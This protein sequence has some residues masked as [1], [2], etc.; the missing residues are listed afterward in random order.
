MNNNP[1]GIIPK[2][3]TFNLIVFTT[4]YAKGAYAGQRVGQAFMNEFDYHES[5]GFEGLWE[6]K[7]DV[8][9]W[10]QIAKIVD[11]YQLNT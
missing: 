11:D 8:I 7:N 9:A 10:A 3:S 1:Y 5:P 2:V 4:N 6:E